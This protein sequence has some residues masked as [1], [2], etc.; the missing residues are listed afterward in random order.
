VELTGDFVR[1]LAVQDQLDRIGLPAYVLLVEQAVLERLLYQQYIGGQS[2]AVKLVLNG[3][4][5]NE[6][7]RQLHYLSY[8]S[9]AR[10][11]L[12]SSLRQ[13]LAELDR[14]TGD[15]RRKSAELSALQREESQA[16][17]RLEKE[18]AQRQQIYAKVSEDLE[19]GRKQLSTLKHDEERLSQLV[20]R[21]AREAAARKKAHKPGKRLA[22][23][24]VPEADSG[25]GTF[26]Q[27]KGKLRLPVIGE[28]M[29]HFG[30]QRQDSGLSWK[31]IFI[32]T[33]PGKDVKA[34]AS[35]RVVYA[36]WLRG[37]GNLLILDHGDG[38]MSL[39]GNN[40]ALLK[41]VG[42]ET[43]PGEAI[44]SVGNT[45][46]SPISGLYFELR[47]RGRPF[48]PLPWVKLR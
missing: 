12:L 5:P 24:A 20:E 37:F 7:A 28:L 19:K 48:D 26:R 17:Q 32:A 29:N 35:G 30:G 8:I 25:S 39:Y 1:I 45:G 6:I 41:Q 23:K 4:D 44:A 46:G 15:T 16:M 38:Y 13:N 14:L 21:L 3:K 22:N 9:R 2:D 31:G 36:D 33:K 27:L 10:A 42:E 40:E 18:K 43:S 47:Y 11:E 34:S